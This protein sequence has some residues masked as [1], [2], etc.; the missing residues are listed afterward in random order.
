MNELI[1]RA[2]DEYLY[3][4]M[5]HRMCLY[6][7]L[8]K[9]IIFTRSLDNINHDIGMTISDWTDDEFNNVNGVTVWL[10]HRKRFYYIPYAELQKYK[11]YYDEYKLEKERRKIWI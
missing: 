10:S 3:K 6:P 11:R 2:P 7:L 4:G 8:F 5:T 9:P 1:A